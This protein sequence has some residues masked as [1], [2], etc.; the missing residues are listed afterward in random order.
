MVVVIVT[1]PG[2]TSTS[3]ITTTATSVSV[4]EIITSHNNGV[5][6]STI[7]VSEFLVVLDVIL[8]LFQG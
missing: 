6:T 8:V 1:T 3:T 5:C 7:M 4:T 2:R